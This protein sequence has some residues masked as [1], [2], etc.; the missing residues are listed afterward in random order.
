VYAA[1]S[2]HE[3]GDNSSSSSSRIADFVQIQLVHTVTEQRGAK[4]YTAETKLSAQLYGSAVTAATATVGVTAAATGDS[5]CSIENT[6]TASATATALA[7]QN[8]VTATAAL[9]RFIA[10]AVIAVVVRC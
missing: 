9:P 1:A 2:W 3:L 10:L 7:V 4:L 5:A 6:T 8:A